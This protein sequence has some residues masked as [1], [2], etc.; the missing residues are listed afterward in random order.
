MLFSVR[1]PRLDLRTRS[2]A[3]RLLALAGLSASLLAHMVGCERD[4]YLDQ[5]V[6]GR[7]EITP[8]TVPILERLVA[9]EGPGGQATIETTPVTP[10]DL[11]PNVEAYRLGPGD[12][13]E[14]RVQDLFQAGA[15]ETLP[16]EVDPRGFIDLPRIGRLFVDGLT[17][18]E[19]KAMIGQALADKGIILRD[20]EVSVTVPRPRKLT[21][22]IL[23]GVQSPGLYG[24][25]RP[26]YRLLEALTAAG[27]FSEN[28]QSVYV[29]RSVPL[30]EKLYRGSGPRPSG[31]EPTRPSDSLTSPPPATPT[32]PP[33]PA[34]DLIDLIDELSK[35]GS[36]PAAPASPEGGA[37]PAIMPS[38]FSGSGTGGAAG[39]PT[40]APA[41]H[42]PPIDLPGDEPPKAADRPAPAPVL[43]PSAP[44]A[45]P[46]PPP[47][48]GS[49]PAGDAAPMGQPAAAQQP[50]QPQEPEKFWVFR[51]G[52][53]VQVTRVRRTGP[54]RPQQT[55][56]GFIP[57]AGPRPEITPEN[58]VPVEIMKP[59]E[60]PGAEKLVTQR[61][62]EVPMAP[63]LAGS[64]Q[65]N[66]VIR[67]GD[68][69]RVPSAPEGVVYLEGEVNRPGVFSLPG[70]GRLTLQ[71]AVAAAGGLSNLA[72]PERVDLTRMV[73][74]DRQATIRL[75]YR[76]IRE[77]TMPD[78][79][80]KA[81]DVVNFGTNFWAFPLAVI[82]NGFR[83]SYGFGFILDRNFDENVF[84]PRQGQR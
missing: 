66:I 28:V 50:E 19:V 74:P 57:N 83:A 13:V 53:W 67:P 52:K 40:R 43:P 25:S 1:R 82:R 60:V 54:V 30:S 12:G 68:I 47:A 65:F 7:W 3:A 10:D 56:S 35:P 38:V 72:V 17:E 23:G 71:R 32:T 76:A 11:I 31:S 20:P 18:D 64:A 78:V 49:E 44:A 36:K 33:K 70:S 84:G 2:R 4:S 22:N 21:Y 75:N 9:I 14:V 41:G 80:L 26:D 45:T 55:E 42:E 79:F 51:D 73:G 6:T 48:S 24:I 39:A 15:E 5:S 59:Q 29:I 63:L 16:R 62:V 8:T 27:R 34:D 58:P 81:D 61:V 69:I 46:E 77:G 37:R